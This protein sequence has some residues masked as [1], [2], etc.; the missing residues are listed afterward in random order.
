MA[1]EET[2]S[3][4]LVDVETNYLDEVKDTGIVVFVEFS[5]LNSLVEVHIERLEG[6]LVH[7]VYDA[8]LNEQEVEHG[9]LSSYSSV[10]FTRLGNSLLS[11]LSNNL[12]LLDGC[13]SLLGD[14]NSLNESQVLKN[15][16]RIGVRQVLEE[17]LF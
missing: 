3:D 8:E 9:T 15:G 16:G 6:V 13:G 12:L 4:P 1:F 5:S 7:V 14:F 11:L 2:T 10:D 17:L